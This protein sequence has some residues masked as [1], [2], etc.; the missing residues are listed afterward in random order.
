MY[1]IQHN[2]HGVKNNYFMKFTKVQEVKVK[3]F[4]IVRIPQSL[5]I[6]FRILINCHYGRLFRSCSGNVDYNNAL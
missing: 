2:S 6:P 5:S 4:E 1:V 3:K